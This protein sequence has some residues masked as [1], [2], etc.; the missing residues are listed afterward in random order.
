MRYSPTI[1]VIRK[2]RT[3]YD[4]LKVDRT[5]PPEV[6]RAAYRVLSQKYHPDRNRNSPKAVRI[7]SLINRAYNVLAD[8]E[9]RR[10]HDAWIARKEGDM[11]LR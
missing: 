7:M 3:H 4:N 1:R 5:A 6:I 11:R 9:K 8:P 2:V 10:R